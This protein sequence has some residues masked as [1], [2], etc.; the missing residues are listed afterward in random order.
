[1]VCGSMRRLL[2]SKGFG[3]LS[4][5]EQKFSFALSSIHFQP[6]DYISGSTSKGTQQKVVYNGCLTVCQLECYASKQKRL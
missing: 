5:V 4:L 1:M 6:N 2:A 3:P